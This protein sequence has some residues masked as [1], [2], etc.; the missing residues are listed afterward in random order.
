MQHLHKRGGSLSIKQHSSSP[1]TT[2]N[3]Q[4]KVIQ[5]FCSLYGYILQLSSMLR[6]LISMDLMVMEK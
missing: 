3:G 2:L 6:S 5:S 1:P 4:H